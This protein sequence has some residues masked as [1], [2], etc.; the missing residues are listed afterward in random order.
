[1]PVRELD[2]PLEAVPFTFPPLAGRSVFV[3]GLGGGCDVI[4]A[5]AVSTLLD[6]SAARIVYGNTKVDGIGP[7]ER[8]TPH[9]GRVAS[10]PPEPGRKQRGCGR[11]ALDHAVPR[12]RHGSPW[13]V[14]LADDVAEHDLPGE[15]A[16]LG[17]DLLV[18]VDAG[19]DSIASKRGKGHRGRDQRILGVL[20][21][22]GVPVV[23]VVVAPGCDGESSV[24]D[25]GRAMA[26]HAAAGRYRGCFALAPLLPVL[27]S[28]SGGLNEMRTPRIMLAAADGLLQRDGDKMIVPR[29]CKPAVPAVWLATAYV[30]APD[31]PSQPDLS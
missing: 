15:L 13:I 29:G 14:Q 17:F 27:R 1:V 22:T 30:F 19:G 4:T 2:I 3:L 18:G 26:Q 23:H 20:R 28:L 11:A 10:P 24:D 5:L 31:D 8:L 6:G 21:R 12:D 7:V 25:L 16:S 9:I